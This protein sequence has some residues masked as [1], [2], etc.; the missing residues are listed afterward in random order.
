MQSGK[1]IWFTGLSA[2]GK[3]TL[4]EIL[5]VV[6]ETRGISVV[7]LDGD[8]LRQG[9]NRDLGFSEQDRTENLRRAG[10]VAKILSDI[11]HTVIAAFITPLESVRK[12]LR[13]LFAE[14]EFVEIFLDCPLDVCESRDPKGLYRR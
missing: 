8:V 6:L 9:L 5:K 10:E 1:T 3:S 13:A 2:S 4:S 7:L 14:G 12:S 11:G